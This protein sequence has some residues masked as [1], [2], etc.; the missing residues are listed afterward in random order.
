MEI[1]WINDL[2]ENCLR[3][4]SLRDIPAAEYNQIIKNKDEVEL[5]LA[6]CFPDTY[7][8]G[9]SNLGM[10]I[11]YSTMNELPYVWCERVYAPWGDMYEQMK[12]NGVAL[13]AA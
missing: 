1:I 5:R 6:F 2:N 7:E 11:L 12:Q 9:M 8:I 13:Y 10:G 3:C 4:R